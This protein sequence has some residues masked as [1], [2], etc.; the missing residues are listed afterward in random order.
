[1][2]SKELKSLT[3]IKVRLGLVLV[4]IH[5]WLSITTDSVYNVNIVTPAEFEYR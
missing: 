1:M 4:I 2:H 5:N 3:E